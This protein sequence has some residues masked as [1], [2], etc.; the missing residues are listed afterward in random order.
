MSS[1]SNQGLLQKDAAYFY[2]PLH[3]KRRPV[4]QSWQLQRDA[5]IHSALSSNVHAGLT[6]LLL[7]LYVENRHM[8]R[9]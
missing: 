5:I 2:F 3:P 8:T 6:A 7:Y 1:S 9:E 4:V